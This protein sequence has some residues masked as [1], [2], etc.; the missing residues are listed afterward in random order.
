MING[1]LNWQHSSLD[2]VSRGCFRAILMDA[3]LSFDLYQYNRI[4]LQQQ[5]PA[6][7]CV[8]STYTG[9]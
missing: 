2:C 3:T 8:H 7:D 9:T 5:Q 6:A 1:S 4:F